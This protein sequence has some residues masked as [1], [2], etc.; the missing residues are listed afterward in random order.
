MKH[1]ARNLVVALVFNLLF[2]LAHA[3][4]QEPKGGNRLK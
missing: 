1:T 4:E 2:T 3:A